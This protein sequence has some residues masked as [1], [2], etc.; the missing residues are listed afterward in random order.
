MTIAHNVVAFD[1]AVPL[2]HQ[3]YLQLR[4]EIADGLWLDRDD[5]PGEKELATLYG[6]SVIT[7]RAA[8]DRL[9]AEGWVQRQRGRGTRAIHQPIPTPTGDGPALIP[10]EFPRGKRLPYRYD[11]LDASVR[12]APADACAAFN[13]PPG[14]E[15][16]QCKRLRRY[17]GKP[18]S[19]THNAQR[20]E[21]G[22][23]HRPA[24]LRSKPMAEML[25]NPGH[26]TAPNA[27]P[28]A[29]DFGTT[30]RRRTT[31]PHHRRPR[32]A[33][34]LHNARQRRTCQSSGYGSTSIP[35]S[36]R[37]KRQWTSRRAPGPPAR[38][39][40]PTR[41]PTCSVSA[42][43]EPRRCDIATPQ[44]LYDGVPSWADRHHANRAGLGA[45]H[46]SLRWTASL[47]MTSDERRCR[48]DRNDRAHRTQRAR[49]YSNAAATKESSAQSADVP[50]RRSP[51]SSPFHG[52]ENAR[53]TRR[54][55]HRRRTALRRHD[56][57][58]AG[59]HRGPGPRP[60][61]R[62]LPLE[63]VR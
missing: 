47:S 61:G 53:R 1:P 20:P 2:Q 41:S 36:P 22:L 16:W 40:N 13:E 18:H 32:A 45:D 34:H 21:V 31:R 44:H 60:V 23:R 12:I 39:C 35:T 4:H 8:L 33:R 38:R 48:R 56:P 28:N 52:H 19:V 55:P 29:R 63:A 10:V 26:R 24:D 43:L 54:H 46:A 57:A 17:R 37:P 42:V 51:R 30:L 49:C 25:V 11:V 50:H 58:D 62:P 7:S 6:V 3:I 27:A 59:C 5:F 14:T 9:A 15:L